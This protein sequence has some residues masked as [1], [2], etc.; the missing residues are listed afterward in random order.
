MRYLDASV[1]LYYI[2]DPESGRNR[3]A[4]K[5]LLMK[6]AEGSMHGATSVLTWDEIVWA[7][8]KKVGLD[9]AKTEGAKFLRFPGLRLLE[10]NETVLI[11]AQSLV[12]G[13][14]MRPRDAIHAA[15]CIENG[16]EEIITSDPDFDRVEGLRRISL[17]DASASV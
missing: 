7:V 12:D 1:F 9:I 5:S 2:L 17:E 8:K 16:I 6:V 15:C 4:S 13:Y 14:D 10:A 3:I 11:T